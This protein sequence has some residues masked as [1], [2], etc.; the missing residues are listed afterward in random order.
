MLQILTHP[1]VLNENFND[2][3]LFILWKSED[4]VT[5]KCGKVTC[6]RVF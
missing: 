2:H 3:G 1:S 5:V 6:G 4:M